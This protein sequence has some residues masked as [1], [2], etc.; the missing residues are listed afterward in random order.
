MKRKW[1]RETDKSEN[2]STVSNIDN[3]MTYVEGITDRIN[4]IILNH[5]SGEIKLVM[6]P[7]NKISNLVNSMKYSIENGDK[8]DV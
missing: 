3:S 7:Y 8:K 2:K 4:K 6:K 5:G 1:L